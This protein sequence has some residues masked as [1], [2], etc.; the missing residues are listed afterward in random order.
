MSEGA[1]WTGLTLG[2][3]S[4]RIKHDLMKFGDKFS[5]EEATAAL[6][7]VPIVKGTGDGFGC[8][9]P[10][11]FDYL[12]FCQRIGGFRKRRKQDPVFIH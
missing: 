12:T 1:L 3:L 10:L 4:S 8:T 7:E 9:G 5:E 6:Q 11:M 2:I